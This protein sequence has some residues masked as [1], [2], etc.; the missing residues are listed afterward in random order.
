MTYFAANYAQMESAAIQIKAISSQIDTQL[1]DLRARLQ[2]MTWTG[3][4]RTAYQAHQAQWD[5]AIKD[6]NAL[7]QEISAGVGIA[8]ENYMT[9]E[10]GNAAI[11]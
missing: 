6:L 9:T 5:S 10:K 8:R 3:E 2:K 11:W 7:L 4:D 1:D